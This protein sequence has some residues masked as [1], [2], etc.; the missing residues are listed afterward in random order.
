MSQSDEN[1]SPRLFVDAA[2]LIAFIRAE[3]FGVRAKTVIFGRDNVCI[4]TVNL[5]EV[6]Y[7][8][9]RK[10]GVDEQ[11]SRALMDTV[12]DL[13]LETVPLTRGI[14]LDAAHLRAKHYH[15]KSCDISLAD[16]VLLAHGLSGDLIATVDRQILKVAKAEGIEFVKI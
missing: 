13:L 5:L 14:S 7:D 1:R 4:S 9:V 16:S 15:R 8:L 3:P 10:Q 11:E 12:T 6:E 2:L